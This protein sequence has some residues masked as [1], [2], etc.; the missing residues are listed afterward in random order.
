MTAKRRPRDGRVVGV[1][2]RLTRRWFLMSSSAV[3]L[4]PRPGSAARGE[5]FADGTWFADDGTG[6]VD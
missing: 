2:A 6:W 5:P 1:W 4:L 3:A